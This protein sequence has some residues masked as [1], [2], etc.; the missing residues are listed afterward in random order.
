MEPDA[1]AHGTGGRTGVR[2][3]HLVRAEGNVMVA[4]GPNAEFFEGLAYGY[5]RDASGEWKSTGTI[6]DKR[7]GWR[8]VTGGEVKCTGGK[9][10]EFSCSSVD[11]LSFIPTGRWCE[12]RDHAERPLGV[13]GRE[14]AAASSGLIGRM[15]GRCS[16]R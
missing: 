16:W 8:R 12:A 7:A 3:G 15:D 1:A 9:A 2:F 14:D 13:D 6:S 5:A 11:M 4:A 10:D